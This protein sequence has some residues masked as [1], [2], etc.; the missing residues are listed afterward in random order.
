MTW[1][2]GER[3]KPFPGDRKAWCREKVPRR[4]PCGHGI[5]RAPVSPGPEGTEENRSPRPL[6][7]SS[8]TDG[9]PEAQVSPEQGRDHELDRTNLGFEALLETS[10]AAA[11][12]PTAI[13]RQPCHPYVLVPAPLSLAECPSG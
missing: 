12:A 13:P 2:Q 9:D 1:V 7:T 4:R 5:G 6:K 11:P 3:G 10:K 8:F